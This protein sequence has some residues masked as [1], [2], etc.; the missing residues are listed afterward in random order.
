MKLLWLLVLPCCLARVMDVVNYS[1][2]Q[3]K[4]EYEEKYITQ[5]IDHFNYLGPAGANGQYQ[6]RYFL[7]RKNGFC[8]HP[9]SWTRKETLSCNN[10][11]RHY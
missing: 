8:F 11:L 4:E 6:M 5:Y 3:V 10:C 2:D 9:S 1:S 7:S